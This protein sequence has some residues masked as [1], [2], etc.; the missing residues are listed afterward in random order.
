MKTGDSELDGRF[1]LEKIWAHH[2]DENDL[3]YFQWIRIFFH[4]FS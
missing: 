3:P 4:F 1:Y 2:Y